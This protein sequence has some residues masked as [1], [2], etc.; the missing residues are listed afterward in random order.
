M[1]VAQALVPDLQVATMKAIAAPRR[2]ATGMI[3]VA[4]LR[5][6]DRR[7]VQAATMTTIVA[8]R[9]V[10]ARPAMMITID[11]LPPTAIGT[12]EGVLRLMIERPLGRADAT[13][14]TTTVGRA[15]GPAMT[16]TIGGPR[17]AV[18]AMIGAD[19]PRMTDRRLVRAA[20]TMIGVALRAAPHVMMRT[21]GV[22]GTGTPVVTLKRHDAG[23]K[24]GE[25]MTTTT[26]VRA[27]GPAMMTMIADLRRAV[28]AMIGADSPRMTTTD[29]VL[30]HPRVLVR[31]V[32]MTTIAG[33]LPPGRDQEEASPK[34]P[35]AAV[36]NQKEA[37]LVPRFLLMDSMFAPTS[38]TAR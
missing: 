7:L 27:R 9:R 34:V 26:V 16:M 19:S 33:P 37:G 30:G 3:G 22:D 14:M 31:P 23:G 36:T 13:T 28:I 21:M 5:M 38:R 4:S 2:A 1:I 11:G 18:I 24:P 8:A 12:T 17:R 6:I 29:A 10:A 35:V 32:T 20:M 15:P 25:T